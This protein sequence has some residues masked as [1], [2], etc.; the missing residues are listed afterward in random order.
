MRASPI[1]CPD[2]ADFSPVREQVTF[3][4]PYLKL[5]N[6]AGTQLCLTQ[7]GAQRLE[8]IPAFHDLVERT[9]DHVAVGDRFMSGAIM[10]QKEPST[11]IHLGEQHGYGNKFHQASVLR[12]Q[13]EPGTLMKTYDFTPK[14]EALAQFWTAGLLA[15]LQHG[16]ITAPRP[17]AL[18][19]SPHGY[20]ITFSEYLTRT[21]LYSA[22]LPTHADYLAQQEG[23]TIMRVRNHV[24]SE[25]SK[26]LGVYRSLL[27]LDLNTHNILPETAVTPEN[28]LTQSYAV[29][30]QP[31]PL[32][33]RA[34]VIAAMMAA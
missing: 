1:D 19:T 23:F 30:D 28:M 34:V 3:G 11:V 9:T 17:Y 31:R 14:R 13:S 25:L 26:M 10:V 8:A 32:G 16:P 15:R 6:P 5:Q 2:I 18:L 27:L 4:V 29:I 21:T 24:A 20:Q 12:P 33:S 22:L 7:A